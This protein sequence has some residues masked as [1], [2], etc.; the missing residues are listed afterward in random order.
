MGR[1]IRGDRGKKAGFGLTSKLWSS[2]P[3]MHFLSNILEI[4]QHL[5]PSI[6]DLLRRK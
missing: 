4:T 2:F 1:G 5:I 6:I 3:A